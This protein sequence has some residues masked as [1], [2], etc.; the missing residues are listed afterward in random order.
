MLSWKGNA[1]EVRLRCELGCSGGVAECASGDGQLV[2]LSMRVG[3]FR[4]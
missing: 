3:M 4:W 2:R 1:Q